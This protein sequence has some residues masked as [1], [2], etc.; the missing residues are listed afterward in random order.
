MIWV[1]WVF[2]FTN[3]LI[4]MSMLGS[5]RLY[6]EGLSGIAFA[7]S[8]LFQYDYNLVIHLAHKSFTGLHV[9]RK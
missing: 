8:W 3:V 9:S 1:V 5:G 7:W 2:S 6:C 4:N